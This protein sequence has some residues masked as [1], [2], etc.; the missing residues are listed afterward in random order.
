[1]RV[2][3]LFIPGL[4]YTLLNITLGQTEARGDVNTGLMGDDAGPTDILSLERAM[5]GDDADQFATPN[6]RLATVEDD[7]GDIL[8]GDS[9]Y[10][11]NTGGEEIMGFES[12]FPA[13]DTTNDV[14][15]L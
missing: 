14:S 11:V 8:G 15:C 1:M 10:Q 5:L 4:V 3:Q 2:R 9:S 12:S 6:D 13:I 7:D